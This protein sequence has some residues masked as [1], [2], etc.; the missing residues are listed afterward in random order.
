MTF[1]EGKNMYAGYGA[2]MILNGC[3][4]SVDKGK[5]TVI[6]GPNGAG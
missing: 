6:V 4:I 1:F 3:S 2:T 5:I